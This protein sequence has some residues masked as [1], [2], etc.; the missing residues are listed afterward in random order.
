MAVSKSFGALPEKITI[1]WSPAVLAVAGAHGDPLLKNQAHRS[2]SE[3]STVV[4]DCTPLLVS[5][6]ERILAKR[7][8]GDDAWTWSVLNSQTGKE[9]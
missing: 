4:K 6:G 9:L 3:N 7:T 2:T 1:E 8:R 5:D